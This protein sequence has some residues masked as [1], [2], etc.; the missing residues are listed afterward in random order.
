MNLTGKFS[1]I[2][3][4]RPRGTRMCQCPNCFELF[5]GESTFVWHRV[6][7]KTRPGGNAAELVLGECRDPASKGMALSPQ[8]VWS[9]RVRHLGGAE[10]APVSASKDTGS[11]VYQKAA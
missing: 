11:G 1:G 7:S 10:G 2:G 6:D 9:L 5:S 4:L 3:G 8:G